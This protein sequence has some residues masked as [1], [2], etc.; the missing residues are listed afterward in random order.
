MAAPHFFKVRP[1]GAGRSG[2]VKEDGHAES[3]PDLEAC[4]AGE[5]NALLELDSGDGDEGD[6][7]GSADARMRTLLALEQ[8]E[9]RL[10]RKAMARAALS[11]VAA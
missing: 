7:V 2:F 4:L 8:A 6:D 10:R 11:G 3:A 1:I 5:K 9:A